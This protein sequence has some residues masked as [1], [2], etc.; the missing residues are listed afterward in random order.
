MDWKKVIMAT[1]ILG[2][3]IW[4][5]SDA[6]AGINEAND[7]RENGWYYSGTSIV[8]S[9]QADFLI[10]KY[11]GFHSGTVDV[12]KT[13]PLTIDYDF[14]TK[15]TIPYLIQKPMAGLDK[16]T[17]GLS[18]VFILVLFLIPMMLLLSAL[19]IGNNKDSANEQINESR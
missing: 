7:I 8:T 9:E 17:A 12:I 11:R 15:E 3:L 2:I 19:P 14:A 4:M 10:S 16:L 5:Y 1:I 13:D 18:D 6:R